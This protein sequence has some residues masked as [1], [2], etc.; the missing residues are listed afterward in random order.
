MSAS[1]REVRRL[2][3]PA[4]LTVL[5]V[6]ALV[7]LGNWQVRR[8]AWKESLIARVNDRLTQPPVDMSGHDLAA[9]SQSPSF[10]GENEYRPVTL[11]GRYEPSGEALVFTS[12]GEP[13]GRY[14][15]PGYWVFTPLALSSG[16][17][18]YVNRGFVPED[19][20][21]AYGPPPSG[22]VAVTGAI[23]ANEP[24]N[25][26]TPNPDLTHR[27][28]YA[29][30]IPQLASAT[31]APP[32]LG[33]FI[34][35]AASQAPPSGLPQ[36]GETRTLFPNDHLAYAVTWYGLALGLVAVFLSFAWTRLRPP[37]GEDA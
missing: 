8:L 22:D 25:W 6:W 13:K 1:R 2:V 9:Q 34:D 3:V 7:S 19:H 31:A 36:P 37:A 17:N 35:L 4:V 10:I 27:V 32:T 16:G 26:F 12:L 14:G 15:G 28:F 21:R 23:R 5:V 33:L 24:G 11:R 20:K 30:N 18:V 29:R